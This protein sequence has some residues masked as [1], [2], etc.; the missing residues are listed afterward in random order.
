MTSM[1]YLNMV[2]ALLPKK[3]TNFINKYGINRQT[4]LREDIEQFQI[5]P[6]ESQHAIYQIGHKL[7]LIEEMRFKVAQW[8]L[9]LKQD[10]TI[11]QHLKDSKDLE[12]DAP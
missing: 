1:I 10:C 7:G 11:E 5:H 12:P 9:T 6:E 3:I 4:Q 2:L 8:S